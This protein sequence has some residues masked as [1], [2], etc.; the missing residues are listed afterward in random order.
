MF[1]LLLNRDAEWMFI[2]ENNN[3]NKRVRRAIFLIAFT[4]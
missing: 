2:A 1:G 3:M 4:F